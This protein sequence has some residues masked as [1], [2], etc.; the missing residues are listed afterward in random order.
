MCIVLCVVCVCVVVVHLRVDDPLGSEVAEEHVHGVNFTPK[1]AV[2]LTII[3]SG[4][5]TETRHHVR[6][7]AIK[8]KE[9]DNFLQR[10]LA[11]EF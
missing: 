8:I 2:I 10:T 1:V 11:Q 5:V 4:Q 6:P 3:T 7:C 9:M